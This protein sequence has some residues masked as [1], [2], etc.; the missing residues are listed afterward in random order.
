ML[1]LKSHFIPLQLSVEKN[2]VFFFNLITTTSRTHTISLVYYH[3]KIIAIK[4]LK[5]KL[6]AKIG[7]KITQTNYCL[8]RP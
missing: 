7:R 8:Y 6:N 2:F 5:V 1:F 3:I 4:M